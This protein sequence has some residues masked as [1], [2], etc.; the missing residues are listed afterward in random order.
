MKTP[1]L[2]AMSGRSLTLVLAGLTVLVLVSSMPGALSDAYER[3]GLYL[4][5]R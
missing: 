3:G 4:F 2:A 1:L 5:S